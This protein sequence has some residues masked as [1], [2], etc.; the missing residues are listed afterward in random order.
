MKAMN[1][2]IQ[3]AMV[4]MNHRQIEMIAAYNNRQRAIFSE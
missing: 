2:V 3:I 4:V 1:A